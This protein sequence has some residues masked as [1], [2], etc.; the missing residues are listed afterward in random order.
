[1]PV[2]LEVPGAHCVAPPDLVSPLDAEPMLE[3]GP[4]FFER[5][6]GRLGVAKVDEDGGEL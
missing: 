1:M 4:S 5:E 2:A 3:E 6:P